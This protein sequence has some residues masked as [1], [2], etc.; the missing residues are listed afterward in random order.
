MLT[1]FGENV[2]RSNMIGH[3]VGIGFAE[4]LVLKAINE[5]GKGNLD[6]IL[7]LI[8]TFSKWTAGPKMN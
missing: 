2:A 7:N 5:N 4:K 3:F 8:L 6:S 1:K